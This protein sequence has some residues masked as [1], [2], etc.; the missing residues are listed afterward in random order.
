MASVVPNRTERWLLEAVLGSASLALEECLTSGMLS[1]DHTT[2]AFRHE[3]AR[4][5]IEST[6]SPL[7]QQTLHRQVLQRTLP[8]R[9]VWSITRLGPTMGR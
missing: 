9:P 1:L 5:A 7:R 3:L 8:R 2:V 6:L 4:Q